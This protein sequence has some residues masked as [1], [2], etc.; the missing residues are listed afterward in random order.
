MPNLQESIFCPFKPCYKIIDFFCHNKPYKTK[1]YLK[2]MLDIAFF[3]KGKALGISGRSLSSIQSY[4]NIFRE[5]HK[6]QYTASCNV[7]LLG[8]ETGKALNMDSKALYFAGALHDIGKILLPNKVLNANPF[9]EEDMLEMEKHPEF[10]YRILMELHPFSAEVALRHHRYQP[11]PY[12]SKLPPPLD[13]FSERS[14]KKIEDY[15]KIISVL[16]CYEACSRSNGRNKG[17]N[18]TTYELLLRE[19]NECSELVDILFE[20]KVLV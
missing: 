12:P 4:F 6:E 18:L 17:S 19:R 10:S 1:K 8:L 3:D 13:C 16:D 7:A 11:R 20:K 14:L 5:K 9:K 2:F 15:S